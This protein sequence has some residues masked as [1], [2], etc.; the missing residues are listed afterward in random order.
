MHIHDFH[1]GG[2]NSQDILFCMQAEG[3]LSQGFVFHGPHNHQETNNWPEVG[4]LHI[5]KV[6]KDHQTD[7]EC[8]LQPGKGGKRESQ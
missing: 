5:Q 2:R 6:S 3:R 7:H 4:V 8:H 1:G